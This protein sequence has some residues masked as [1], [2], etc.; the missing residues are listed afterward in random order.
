MITDI[1]LLSVLLAVTCIVTFIVAYKSAYEEELDRFIAGAMATLWSFAAGLVVVIVVCGILE[2]DSTEEDYKY[3]IQ[4]NIYSLRNSSET[5]GSFTLGSGIINEVEYCYVMYK[6]ENGA[7]KRHKIPMDNIEIIESSTLAPAIY[8]LEYTRKS[9]S[10]LIKYT[11]TTSST[12]DY[13]IVVPKG[14]VIEQFKI[15]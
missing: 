1:T 3:K 15:Y 10:G 5:A 13:R 2:L 14:T 9:R 8:S 12:G 11:N 7:Y 4:Y 6:T